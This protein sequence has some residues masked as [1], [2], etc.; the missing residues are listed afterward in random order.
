MP[1]DLF[2]DPKVEAVFEAYPA[3][4]RPPLLALRDL[5]IDTAN[6]TDGVGELVET[7]KWGQPA[8]LTTRPRTGSTIRIDALKGSETGYAMFFHCQS[9]LVPT[10]RE[11]YPDAF[12]FEGNRALHFTT[13]ETPPQDALRH[14]I[15][16][17]LTYH[18]KR[19]TI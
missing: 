5:I 2:H 4:L 11:L 16:V 17:A 9:R 13:D 12:T 14:C 10:F 1:R 19:R 7:L 6:G 3:R 18:S 15:A 8:Y